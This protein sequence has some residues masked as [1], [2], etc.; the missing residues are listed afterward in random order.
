MSKISK[1]TNSRPKVHVVL[2][3]NPITHPKKKYNN[4]RFKKKKNCCD[5]TYSETCMQRTEQSSNKPS[6]FLNKFLPTR[7][8]ALPW[9]SLVTTSIVT[10]LK[11]S[12]WK[13]QTKATCTIYSRPRN[14]MH[15]SQHPNACHI[16]MAS[17][18]HERKS[19]RQDLTLAIFGS[20]VL[21]LWDPN[22]DMFSCHALIVLAYHLR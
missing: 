11:E 13:R 22:F 21:E 1:T 8:P 10:K 4:V 12:L 20:L 3:D 6:N 18:L 9:W 17:F 16:L 5:L 19:K 15:T 14:I 2:E 7:A